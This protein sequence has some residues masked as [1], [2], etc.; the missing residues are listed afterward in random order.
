MAPAR[1]TDL[2]YVLGL[3][4]DAESYRA[5]ISLDL[6]GLDRLTEQLRSAHELERD[7]YRSPRQWIKIDGTSLRCAP[8]DREQEPDS[9]IDKA[10]N[11]VDVDPAFEPVARI[12]RNSEA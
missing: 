4:G 11:R 6:I 5:Q 2:E 9:V 3:R 8:C 12:G 7:W 10:R 1:R